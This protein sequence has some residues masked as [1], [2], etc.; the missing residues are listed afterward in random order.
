LVPPHVGREVEVDGAT[1]EQLLHDAREPP[2]EKA[3]A[4]DEQQVGLAPLGHLATGFGP[5]GQVVSVEDEHV[6]EVVCEHS[7][8]AEP[9]DAGPEHDRGRTAGTG[10]RRSGRCGHGITVA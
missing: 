6:R 4:G 10:S 3:C 8:G 9:A 7:G 2:F 5:V 1:V